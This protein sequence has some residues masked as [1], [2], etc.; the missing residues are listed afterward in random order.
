MLTVE[1]TELNC[2]SWSTWPSL[3]SSVVF[4]RDQPPVPT[5]NGVG[6]AASEI[7][8]RLAPELSTLR[9]EPP[10]LIVGEQVASSTELFT[11]DLV[12]FSEIVDDLLLLAMDPA[13]DHHDDKMPWSYFQAQNVPRSN[14]LAGPVPSDAKAG[15]YRCFL[16]G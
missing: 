3:L 7:L 6:R 8:Q 10:P 1:T 4:P 9:S 11:Q 16:V 5:E 2:L 12:L 15:S 13:G 14:L